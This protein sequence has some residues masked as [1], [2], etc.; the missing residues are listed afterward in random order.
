MK[1]ISLEIKLILVVLFTILLVCIFNV[2]SVKATI[3]FTEADF[4]V[5]GDLG[6]VKNFTY[7]KTENSETN[8]LQINLDWKK[9]LE[10]MRDKQDLLEERAVGGVAYD[11]FYVKMPE[12]STEAKVVYGYGENTIEEQLEIVSIDNEEFAKVP[13]LIAEFINNKYYYSG[14][15]HGINIRDCGNIYFNDVDNTNLVWQV[16]TPFTEENGS[17]DQDY[18]YFRIDLTSD[19]DEEYKLGGSGD[20]DFWEFS[21]DRIMA[22]GNCYAIL[23][24]DVDLGESITVDYFGTLTYDGKDELGYYTYKG[25]ITDKSIFNYERLAFQFTEY[26]SLTFISLSFEGDLVDVSEEVIYTDTETNIRIDTTTE[27]V[28][29][30]TNLMVEEITEG[31]EYSTVVEILGDEVNNFVAYDIKILS[32]GVEIQPNGNVKISLPIPK[33]FDTSKLVVYRINEDGTKVE[34]NV[35]VEVEYAVFET[36]HFST[37]VLAESNEQLQ[38][39]NE[40]VDNTIVPDAQLPQT[41]VTILIISLITISLTSL[42]ISAILTKKI[43]IK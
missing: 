35:T 28:P 5:E 3:E 15:T 20:P 31:N 6:L 36:D 41:G 4:N 8:Q 32:Q 39:N 17:M 1:K 21:Y 2:N 16:Y 34:Y 37:Y 40:T 27:I 29:A 14:K 18:K 22:K 23:T 24:T 30:G 10:V 12:D 19:I 33:N 11:Y 25:K 13:Y 7:E 26:N 43:K 42:I 38:S 9:V